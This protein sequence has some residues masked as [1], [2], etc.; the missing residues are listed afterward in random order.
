[1][2]MPTAPKRYSRTGSTPRAMDTRSTASVRGYNARWSRYAKR[3]LRKRPLCVSCLSAG[4]Y[5]QAVLVDHIVAIA[6]GGSVWSEDNHQSLCRACHAVKT[7]REV[8]ARRAIHLN[9]DSAAVLA[10]AITLEAI[11]CAYSGSH[12]ARMAYSTPR[13][14]STPEQLS[15]P[16]PCAWTSDPCNVPTVP[17]DTRLLT[18]CNVGFRTQLPVANKVTRDHH[19]A[20]AFVV[21]VA[22]GVMYIWIMRLWRR[23]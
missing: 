19:A 10:M 4:H 14:A 13:T 8:K 1:M 9:K 2:G 16:A 6:D 15:A 11:G 5:T 7:G 3:F 21:C 20:L 18:D 12:T 23:L 22:L 17:S